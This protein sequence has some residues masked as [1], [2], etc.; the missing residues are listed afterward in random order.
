MSTFI[1]LGL[2]DSVI[3]SVE[4]FTGFQVFRVVPKDQVNQLVTSSTTPLSRRRAPSCR[5]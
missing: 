5:H 2:H 3:E 4:S 1:S